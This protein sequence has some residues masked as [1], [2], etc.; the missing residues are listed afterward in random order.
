[1]TTA[2]YAEL[3]TSLVEAYFLVA[4]ILELPERHP[5]SPEMTATLLAWRERVWPLV[6]EEV[7]RD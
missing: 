2:V 1:V 4:E 6:A 3:L 7:E 5:V